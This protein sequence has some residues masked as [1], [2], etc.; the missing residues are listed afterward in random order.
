VAW[1]TNMRL[2]NDVLKKHEHLLNEQNLKISFADVNA[3]YL[4]LLELGKRLRFNKIKIVKNLPN[5]TKKSQDT[6]LYL[7]NFTKS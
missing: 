1:K 7:V 2:G 6:D 3:L 5:K 4:S